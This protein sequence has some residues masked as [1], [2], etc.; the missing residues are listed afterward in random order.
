MEGLINRIT[1]WLIQKDVIHE[2]EQA[3]YHYGLEILFST[4]LISV[5]FLILAIIF[6]RVYETIAFFSSF[7]FIRKY[8]GGYH[9]KS[10]IICYLCSIGSYMI[11]IVILLIV[12]KNLMGVFSLWCT[13]ISTFVILAFAPIIHPNRNT[14]IKDSQHFKKMCQNICCVETVFIFTAIILDINKKIV[15]AV[16]LGLSFAAIA[17]V[18]EKLKNVNKSLKM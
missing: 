9:A 7:V 12:P 10:R 8:A 4:A 17:L 2:K 13:V 3:I 14:T 6:D 11:F 1:I 5:S 18:L 15:F 16:S